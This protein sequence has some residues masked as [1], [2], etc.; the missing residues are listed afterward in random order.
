VTVNSDGIVN[1]TVEILGFE[2]FKVFE[3]IAKIRG[4]DGSFDDGR[5]SEAC[6]RKGGGF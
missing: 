1:G 6:R 2:E 3:L 4:D 5:G